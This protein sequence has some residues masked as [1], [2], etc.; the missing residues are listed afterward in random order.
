MKQIKLLFYNYYRF[1]IYV[2]NRDI[3][4]FMS[5]LLIVFIFIIYMGGLNF[6]FTI[7][8]PKGMPFLNFKMIWYFTCFLSLFFFIFLYFKFLYREKYK[9]IFK[10]IEDNKSSKNKAF[11]IIFP[12]IGFVVFNLGWI[13]KMLQNQGKW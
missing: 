4:P 7:L 13:L 8:F 9:I 5:I 12:V 10:E 11:A 1:Q 6:L 2:G 3:A